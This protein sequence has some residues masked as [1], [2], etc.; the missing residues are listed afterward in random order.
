[1]LS[2]LK[3]QSTEIGLALKFGLLIIVA[4]E[5]RFPYDSD[6]SVYPKLLQK[7]I[8]NFWLFLYSFV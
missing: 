2:H 6:S 3:G 5:P 1:M 4:V 8:K 7:W